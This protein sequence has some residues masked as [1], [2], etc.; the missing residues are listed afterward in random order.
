MRSFQGRIQKWIG[1]QGLLVNLKSISGLQ[2][3]VTY[4]TRS[5]EI[6]NTVVRLLREMDDDLNYISN[7]NMFKFHENNRWAQKVRDAGEEKDK[8]KQ[9]IM[10]GTLLSECARI[11]P[12]VNITNLTYMFLNLV[13]QDLSDTLDLN[14]D[15]LQ[16]EV[17]QTTTLPAAEEEEE[18]VVSV[19]L[20]E[21]YS[22]VDSRAFM[23]EF[24]PIIL[25]EEPPVTKPSDALLYVLHT[26]GTYIEEP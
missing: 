26:V 16:K 22:S 10:Y 14:L 3:D 2:R 21:I 18:D 8:E 5:N 25:K 15:K 23:N 17:V 4:D 6:R 13:S 12:L 11:S 1:P 7:H 24:L 20:Y 19:T 9:N